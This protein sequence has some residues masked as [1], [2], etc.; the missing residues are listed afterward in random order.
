MSVKRVGNN[1]NNILIGSDFQ[2]Y[3]YGRDGDDTLQGNGNNDW[4]FGGSGV[5]TAVF[6][7]NFADYDFERVGSYL[8]V[9]HARG[10]QADAVDL[11]YS[12]VELLKFA[13]QSVDLRIANHNPIARA[14]SNSAD[15]VKERG[16][17]AN[18]IAGDATARGNVLAND[19]DQ[20]VILLGQTLR[21]AAP[22]TYSGK[23]GTL[24]ISSN[25]AYT[26]TLND[27]DADTQ[28]LKAGQSAIDTF[29]Y[30]VSDG[31]GKSASSTL[32]IT[33]AGT[34]DAPVIT[35][36][37]AAAKGTVTEAG[38]ADSGAP[39]TTVPRATGQ[40]TAADVDAGATATWSGS[41]NGI[42]GAFL[43]EPST[44]KWT[45][46]LDN[47]RAATNK[48]AE[49]Q[50][51]TETFLV[52]VTD[53]KGAKATQPVTVTIV[54]N[55]D[56]PI[57]TSNAAAARGDVTEAGLT[58]TGA[59]LNP[60][61]QVTGQLTS[62]DV[63]A[64][65]TSSWSGSKNGLYG[66][67]AIDAGT[68]K[69]TYTLDNSRDATN[70]L[71]KGSVVT[72][73][74]IA[75][76]TDDKGASTKQTVTVTIHGTNDAPIAAD[77]GNA[78]PIVALAKPDVATGNV[79]D[80]DRDPDTGSILTVSGLAAGTAAGPVT[81]NLATDVQGTYGKLTLASDGTW[82]YTL[83]SLDSDTQHLREGEH[84][85]DVFTYTIA[86]QHGATS[87][88]QI[89]VDVVGV[90]E[91][92]SG[93]SGLT[94]AQFEPLDA[95]AVDLS[96]NFTAIAIDTDI[97]QTMTLVVSDPT[98]TFSGG[99]LPAGFP[100]ITAN[101]ITSTPQ[102]T[103]G[104]FVNIP[105]VFNSPLLNL[106]FLAKGQTL[107]ITYKMGF[108]DGLASGTASYN[109]SIGVTGTDDAPVANADT[110]DADT[111][112]EAGNRNNSQNDTPDDR[113]A[114]GNVLTNDT[115]V[116]TG[117]TITVAGFAAGTQTGPI[118]TGVGN[119]IT[120]IY[121]TL[122][123]GSD[124]AWTYLLDNTDVDTQGLRTGGIGH[125]IFS[126]T[127]MDSQGATATSQLD[128]S[129]KGS[130]DWP[131]AVN[132]VNGAD[133]VT[134]AGAAGLGDATATGN[135]LTNDT[136]VDIGDTKRVIGIRAGSTLP[137]Q[138]EGP[139]T[140]GV[141]TTITGTY[142]TITI[143]TN[144]QWTYTLDNT[145]PDTQALVANQSVTDVFVYSMRD[146]NNTP[147]SSARITITIGGAND[148]PVITSNGGGDTASISV[149]ENTTAVTTVN[150]VDPDAFDTRSY[151]L[152]GADAAFFLIDSLTGALRFNTAPDFENK[153][154]AG[155]DNV[156]NVQV[157][158]TDAAGVFDTQDLAV[159]VLNANEAPT[160]NPDVFF[161]STGTSTGVYDFVPF[162]ANDTDPDGD[163]LQLDGAGYTPNANFSFS[164]IG[165]IFAV[166]AGGAT[167]ASNV[168]SYRVSDGALTSNSSTITL[169]TPGM[170]TDETGNAIDLSAQS[171]TISKIE[172]RGGNDTLTGGGGND[173]FLGGAGDDVLTGNGGNDTLDGGAGT[174]TL[175]GGTGNDTFYFTSAIDGVDTF[176]FSS[177][178]DRI[179]L[180]DAIF[181]GI[182]NGAGGSMDT[183]YL[184]LSSL[185]NGFQNTFAATVRIIVEIHFTIGGGPTS[186]DLFYDS[187]GGDTTSGRVKV[188]HYEGS[189]GIGFSSADLFVI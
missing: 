126:Y 150:A 142:G 75:T 19:Y 20:D 189:G 90:N 3:F 78:A 118:S 34:N 135:A 182:A 16:G 169:K 145:D 125:D 167:N 131:V 115:D 53:G 40:L 184:G 112:T 38:V 57:I 149:N 43:I 76:V 97:G 106:D 154:D 101:N 158:A 49:G 15:A 83:N 147:N 172:G 88:A 96:T 114:V 94:T 144:G 111:V 81:G 25:G 6:T 70:G 130:N 148:A 24:V 18:G 72:E 134:E 7:G 157:K 36:S 180:D 74:F 56:A 99:A 12:D 48:L 175:T 155:A 138:L 120:G 166:T 2:E 186:L 176:D 66:T 84:A 51:V 124:G 63:D 60:S 129:I 86:D 108:S 33:I 1:G 47:T 187:D 146:S 68:G 183:Q 89:N 93:G 92:P 73:S 162:I 85:T 160:A 5:D 174:N 151:S 164:L 39:L 177:G 153:L 113:Q 91:A 55:N 188:A 117:D 139:I 46:Q 185:G 65:A 11:V 95:S 79:L 9:T 45:Y 161:I 27:A 136:D 128:I 87:T 59:P 28:A 179:A 82:I 10:T 61:P 152:G 22:G 132:D 168:I 41:K 14:D 17:V 4:L 121:G 21:V 159:T 13:D 8:R 29:S 35:S 64:G 80:N 102:T 23:Y 54:G 123:L 137:T 26:Y 67:F 181:T 178:E 100:A 44:G 104:G 171:Y 58:D 69:W 156:Y 103:N 107:T 50:T 110:N 37:A 52:T 140:T 30:T 165:T 77:D 163:N 141:G 127:I 98:V 143:G 109:L 31:A 105:A 32:K 119:T 71:A 133:L 42:Y 173:Y 62:S 170:A 116:D 122:T